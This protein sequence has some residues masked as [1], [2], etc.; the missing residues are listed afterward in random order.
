MLSADGERVVTTGLDADTTIH[1]ARTLRP[2]TRWPVRAE[3]AAL[4]R[5]GRTLLAGGADGSVR[6]SIWP[7]ATSRSAPDTC[8]PRRTR[9][10]LPD[11]RQAVTAGADGRMFVWDVERTSVGE[12]LEGHAGKITGLTI[13][14]TARRCTPAPT[15]ARSSSGTSAAPPALAARSTGAS[16]VQRA[17]L[18]PEPGRPRPRDRRHRR[19]DHD[20]RRAHA[21]DPLERPAWSP[22]AGARNGIRARRQAARGRGRRRLPGPGRPEPTGSSSACPASA[23]PS[24]RPPSA[25]T[26]GS[27]RRAVTTGSCSFALPSGRP[28]GRPYIRSTPIRDVSLSPDGRTLAVARPEDG[29]SRSATCPRCSSG[30]GWPTPRRCG[31]TR[32]SRRTGASSWVRAGRAGAAVVDRDLQ[33]GRTPVRRARRA[34]GLGV[35]EPGRRHARD[36]QLGRNGP[37]VGS[38]H[39]AADRR[40]AARPAE[41]HGASAVHARRRV[42]VRDL[43]RARYRWDVRPSSWSRHACAVAGRTLTRAEWQ[44]ALPGR[45]Y[46]P[47]CQG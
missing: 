6:F 22:R 3:Q 33:A 43:R 14:R 36:G 24:T 40:S 11:G 35:D 31:T 2:L 18:R 21:A 1:D 26:A 16:D 34:R 8:R 44:D 32:A 4:S 23:T 13:S 38:A 42:P 9:G 27:W 15:T 28:V 46:E 25:P 30:R 7:P 29:A 10:L 20:H 47:A 45:D 41:P 37:P 12:T 19:D 5:D 39:A 17:A